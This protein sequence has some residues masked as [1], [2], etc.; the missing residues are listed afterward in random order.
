LVS[1]LL[2]LFW[3]SRRLLH[4]SSVICQAKVSQKASGVRNR[5]ADFIARL[6]RCE[7]PQDHPNDGG[8]N[9]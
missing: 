2:A 8:V 4:V 1:C 9:A 7:K 3:R 6:E 5:L